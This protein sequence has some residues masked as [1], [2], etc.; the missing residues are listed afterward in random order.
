[1]GSNSTTNPGN[2]SNSSF[3]IRLLVASAPP[4]ASGDGGRDGP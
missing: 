4:K 2:S 1:L 3:D